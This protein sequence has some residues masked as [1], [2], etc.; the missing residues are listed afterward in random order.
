M[1]LWRFVAPAPETRLGAEETR[2]IIGV[3]RATDRHKSF[4]APRSESA[5][6]DSAHVVWC[7]YRPWSIVVARGLISLTTVTCPCRAVIGY[8]KAP[9]PLAASRSPIARA[10]KARA[11][12]P[13]N[14]PRRRP[15]LRLSAFFAVRRVSV[16]YYRA[17]AAGRKFWL[18]RHEAER[19]G[20]PRVPLRG[21]RGRDS[22]KGLR[23]RAGAILRR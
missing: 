19:L 6:A 18:L 3:H 5:C 4:V 23:A 22:G 15:D 12:V 21:H 11:R 7:R 10:A 13:R 8:T 1:R 17:N 20:E 2:A 16:R 14:A 9:W